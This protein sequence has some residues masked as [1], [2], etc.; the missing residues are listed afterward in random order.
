MQPQWPR[1]CTELRTPQG[2]AVVT[3]VPHQGFSTVWLALRSGGGDIAHAVQD[4]HAAPLFKGLVVYVPLLLIFYSGLRAFRETTGYY[5]GRPS[6]RAGLQADLMQL[7]A[8]RVVRT[9]SFRLR[10]PNAAVPRR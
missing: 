5:G 3:A 7:R 9:A 6:R 10:E 2:D 1:P 4:D 8:V